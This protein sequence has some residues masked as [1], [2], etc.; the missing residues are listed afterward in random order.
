ELKDIFRLGAVCSF[1]LAAYALTL[2][3]T[4]PKRRGQDWLAP[5]QALRLLRDRD[6]AVYMSVSL[7]LYMTTA[8]QGQVTPLLLKSLGIPDKVLAPLTTIAQ[9]SEVLTLIFL[10]VIQRRLGIR[11]TMAMGLISWTTGL[12]VYGLGQPTWLVVAAQ[13]CNGL[14]VVCF[15]VNGQ[16]FL[17]SRAAGHIRASTQSLLIFVNGVG[18]I[19]GSFVAG[20]LRAWTAPDFAPTLLTAAGMSLALVIF[21]LTFFSGAQPAAAVEQPRLAYDELGDKVQ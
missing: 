4:P 18:L 21:F 7:V 16:V 15:M 5:L 10:P 20:E 14:C 1:A 17:N 2:P 12:V 13:A 9:S 11:G 19:G 3:H 6:F 8:M